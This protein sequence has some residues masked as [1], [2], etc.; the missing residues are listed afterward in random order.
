MVQLKVLSLCSEDEAN[1]HDDAIQASGGISHRAR[2]DG[3]NALRK[4]H[5]HLK[6]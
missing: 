4:G 6:H 3:D 2:K 1:K 5:E